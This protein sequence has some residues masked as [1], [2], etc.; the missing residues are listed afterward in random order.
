M[1]FRKSSSL[2][3]SEYP[4]HKDLS[5]QVGASEFLKPEYIYIPLVEGGTPCECLVKVNDKVNVGQV[6]AMKSGRFGLPLHSSISGEVT[7]IDKKMWHA[8]G[9]MVPMIEIKNDYQETLDPSIKPNDVQSLSKEDIVNIAR[10]CGIVGLGGSGFPT[11]VKYQAQ[12]PIQSVI[13]N[14][15][16]CEPFLTADYTLVKT[17]TKKL[18]NGIKYAMKASGATNAYIAIKENKVEAIE[19]LNANIDDPNIQVFKLKDVYPAGWEKYIVQK[20]TKKT[21][22]ALPSEVG[23]VVN[24]VAT[25]VALA[26]AIENNMPLVKK[27]VTFTGKGLKNP[28]N[29]Y[30]KIGSLT[31]EVISNIGGYVPDVD[32]QFIAGGLMTGLAIMF[33]SLVIHRSLG[34]VIALPK[35]EKPA[36]LLPCMGCG[37]CCANCP[38]FLSPIEIKR[39]LDS[40]ENDKLAELR[41]EKCI[42]CG[43]CS[44][45]CPSRIELTDATTKA[46]G[47]V[48]KGRK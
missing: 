5:L 36:P 20:I 2:H 41:A 16:E 34:S 37:K 13:V 12:N 38:V 29:V 30:V 31:N 23:V 35:V 7:A 27:L 26:D 45:V 15:A 22:K 9:M 10:N 18:L 32:L 39:A 14:A 6:L 3:I 1:I 28:Q 24:N 19:I 17:Q 46:R 42:Q 33:D 40:K 48:L 21:Y 44:Y 47:I 8:S 25:L 11:Y 43:L 4:G